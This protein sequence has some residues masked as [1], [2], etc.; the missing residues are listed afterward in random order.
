[1]QARRILLLVNG[2]HKR[3]QLARLL[4]DKVSTHFPASL[5]NL[6]ADVTVICYMAAQQ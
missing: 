4:E 5:L 1:M 2:M 6:H 3:E